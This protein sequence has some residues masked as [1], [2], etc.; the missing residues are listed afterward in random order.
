MLRKIGKI[1]LSLC[2]AFILSGRVNITIA[3]APRI[4]PSQLNR[5]EKKIVKNDI[6]DEIDQLC[7]EYNFNYPTLMKK[8][9]W[10]ESRYGQDKRCGDGGKACGLYQWHY[11]TW[12][13]FQ[14]KFNRYDLDWNNNRDQ[15][16][17]T[18]LA[19]KH[20]YWYRWGTLLRW[21]KGN[22]I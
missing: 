16:V 14:K 15:I 4:P 10:A 2:V 19:L 7:K 20:G 21:Y 11:S 12:K 6:P 13:E 18:I 5:Q 22:P 3:E 1:F 9:A 8:L 17:M